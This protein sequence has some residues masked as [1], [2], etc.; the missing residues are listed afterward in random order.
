MNKFSERGT[1]N[2]HVQFSHAFTLVLNHCDTE[3]RCAQ[4]VR[5]KKTDQ[6]S[7]ETVDQ[8]ELD[9]VGS[10][11]CGVVSCAKLMRGAKR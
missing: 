5:S 10:F 8:P 9:Q 11:V 6:P 2:G 4:F 7:K 3:M 1:I